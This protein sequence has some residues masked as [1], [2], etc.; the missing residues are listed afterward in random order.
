MRLLYRLR[1][2]LQ[3]ETPEL[4]IDDDV[5]VSRQTVVPRE[6]AGSRVDQAAATLFPGFSRVMLARW[7]EGGELTCDGR[8]V[9]PAA[10]LRGGER[11][12]LEAEREIREDWRSAQPV[13][14]RV[15]YE[16]ADLLVI[17]KPVGVVVHPGAGVPDGTLVNGLL[18]HRPALATLPRAGIVH[19]LDKDTSGL[20]LVAASEAAR[21]D[22]IA[23][24]AARTV[25]RRYLAVVA[26]HVAGELLIDAAIG[27]DPDLRTRQQVR[28]DGKP[29]RTRVSVRERYAA[30][31]L[32]EAALETGRTHQIRVHLSHVGHPLVGDS[33]YRVPGRTPAPGTT[34]KL[35]PAVRA[36]LDGLVANFP[37]QALH[38]WRLA[39][40]HP[41]SG[42]EC[43]FEA[44]LPDDMAALVAA[45]ARHAHA[46]GGPS[47]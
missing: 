45:L 17:E 38:A 19:R 44:P 33:R 29:A 25:S 24:L 47:A 13:P 6:L 42:A 2:I 32:I 9:R 16:D 4:P 27:R 3:P 43:A 34:R 1:S 21:L 7:I 26:G 23:A 37:R 8:A 41:R 46:A 12:V 15:L 39:F 22:L 28:N 18:A 5:A 10:R 20:M 36:E 35:A 11:L 40:R 14:F 30:H 31:T